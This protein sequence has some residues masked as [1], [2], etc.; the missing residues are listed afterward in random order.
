MHKWMTYALAVFVLGCSSN[1]RQDSSASGAL[2]IPAGG[3]DYERIV[4]TSSASLVA[5]DLC[6]AVRH[7]MWGEGGLYRVARLVGHTEKDERPDSP[8]ERGFTYVELERLE[9]WFG[10]SEGPTVARIT[11]GPH[12]GGDGGW[13]FNLELGQTVGLLLKVPRERNNNY[14]GLDWL[15]TFYQKE[16]GGY[17][18]GQLFTT[19]VVD[20]E[21]LGRLVKQLHGGTLDDPCPINEAPDYD[22]YTEVG[23]TGVAERSSSGIVPDAGLIEDVEPQP[24]SDGAP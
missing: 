23:T 16:D 1:E 6:A 15:G 21:E 4:D 5:F 3:V 11:G 24:D 13:R 19:R 10:P 22:G 2:A 12:P 9:G 14:P 18:N 7:P 20:A 17:T 8:D